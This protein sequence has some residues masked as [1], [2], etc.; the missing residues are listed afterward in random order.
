MVDFAASVIIDERDE[1]EGVVFVE[2]ARLMTVEI[3]LSD[4]QVGLFNNPL[5][6]KR[7]LNAISVQFPIYIERAKC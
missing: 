2:Y 4:F 3:S 1:T 5:N 6:I 7:I